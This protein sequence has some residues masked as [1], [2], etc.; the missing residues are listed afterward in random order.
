MVAFKLD[1]FRGIRPRLS[2]RNLEPPEAVT[3][4]NLR[5]GSGALE[6]WNEPSFEADESAADTETIYRFR[7]DGSPLWL[8]WTSDVDVARGPVLDD[9]LERTYY[10]GTDLSEPRMTYIGIVDGVGALP[11][12]H[13]RLGIPAPGVSP[14][15]VG[16]ALPDSSITGQVVSTLD[17]TGATA[18]M[19]TNFLR[20][21]FAIEN[22]LPAAMNSWSF[23]DDD[24]YYSGDHT[25]KFSFPV[26]TTLKVTGVPDS[27]HVTV[28]EGNGGSFIAQ[29]S[30]DRNAV[31]AAG[32]LN[33]M[34]TDDAGTGRDG[35]FRFYIPNGITLDAP[36]HGL[37]TGDV[38]RVTGVSKPLQFTIGN[39]KYKSGSGA[40]GGEFFGWES[41][42]SAGDA[43]T[44]TW[45]AAPS[46]FPVDAFYIAGTG[47]SFE[48]AWW[49]L[50]GSGATTYWPLEVTF[51]WELV[52]RD[53]RDY[54]DIVAD[55]EKRVYVYTFVSELGEE[56][57]PSPTSDIVTIP[58]DGAVNVSGFDTP[59][60]A[61]RQ[62]DNMRI[63]RA[64]TGTEDTEF[65]FVAE[66]LDDAADYD[67]TVLDI[68]LGEVLQTATWDPPDT[69][70]VGLIT[71]PNGGMA[72]FKGKTVFFCE[73]YFP[74]AWPPEYEIAVDHDVVGLGVLPQGVLILTVGTPYMAVGSHPRAMSLRHFEFAQ[75]CSSKNSI[76]NTRDSVIYASPDGLVRIGAQGFEVITD[77]YL[78]KREWQASYNPTTIRG[79]WHDSRYFG[80][81]SGGG[82]VFDPFDESVG[83]TTL[84][85]A[86]DAGYVDAETDDL[87][88][89]FDDGGSFD[90]TDISKWDG[91]AGSQKT[92]TW[93][94]ARL[95]AGYPI[96]LGA[97]IVEA[98]SYPVTLKLY[99]DGVLKMTKSVADNEIFRLPGGFMGDFV[100]VEI[101]ATVAIR[102]V[103]V[104]ETIEELL[105]G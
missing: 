19:L 66:I 56:G 82:F 15:L 89:I 86:M 88:G 61:N 40:F 31:N 17:S 52:E 54:Q 41:D 64:N 37:E 83:F 47:Y 34:R 68:A 20:C 46:A 100:Q 103:G 74:H 99:S 42:N 29:G 97:G 85:M 18:G 12:G 24:G 79:F 78:T 8:E 55:I 80:F 58:T 73:P 9:S 59:P 36:T 28:N 27:N 13:R 23:G 38:I 77:K 16:E 4:E 102:Y 65:Q 71:L 101:V 75:S 90:G 49:S 98:D 39:G 43:D 63:Y 70:M 87:Y 5:M 104:A 91:D 6:P 72:G 45:A 76:V 10:A 105:E 2:V 50:A 1:T 94:S 84:D 93:R 92:L 35:Y 22:G 95:K 11:A 69:D 48:Q 3:A 53:G 7:N 25:F 67:D 51:D 81:H 26:G 44:N 21:D 62:I 57:P 33:K 30:N 96:N 60:S 14:T 32:G